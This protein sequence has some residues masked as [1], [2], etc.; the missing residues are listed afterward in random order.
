MPPLRGAAN[1]A[2]LVAAVSA[3]RIDSLSSDHSPASPAMKEFESGDFLRAWGGIAALQY[4]LPAVWTIAQVR[5]EGDRGAWQRA[6]HAQLQA[7]RTEL[8]AAWLAAA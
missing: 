8:A 6:P 4:T 3:G 2:A 1:R 7:S 5:R